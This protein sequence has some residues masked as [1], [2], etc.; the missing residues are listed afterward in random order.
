MPLL[1]RRLSLMT[2]L[3]LF[4]E[5]FHKVLHPTIARG[6]FKVGS[7]IIFGWFAVLEVVYLL[8]HLLH[9][10]MESRTP[11]ESLD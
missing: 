4:P 9:A 11:K 2:R 8:V 1:F 7:A 5:Q 3:E 10:S 6:L